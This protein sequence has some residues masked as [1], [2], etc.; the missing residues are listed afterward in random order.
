VLNKYIVFKMTTKYKKNKGK[1]S[2]VLRGQL[3]FFYIM[4]QKGILM[5]DFAVEI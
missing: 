4:A 3:L 1:G 2:T 5:E